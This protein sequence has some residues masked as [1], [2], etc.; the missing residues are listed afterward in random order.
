MDKFMVEGFGDSQEGLKALI[1]GADVDELN[2]RVLDASARILATHYGLGNGEI[3]AL[4]WQQPQS[5]LAQLLDSCASAEFSSVPLTL[6]NK[7]FQF[8][9]KKRANADKKRRG[10]G[11]LLNDR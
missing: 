4:R 10:S 6:S 11:Q 8:S 2:Y 9:G 5:A 7:K 3:A 1:E